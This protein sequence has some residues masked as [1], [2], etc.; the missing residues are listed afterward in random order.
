MRDYG[1][2]SPSFWTGSTG[3]LL[4]KCPESQ[5]VAIYLMTCPQANMIGLYYMP[6]MYVGHETGL[7]IE[8]ASKGLAWA[9]E[10]GFCSY[11]SSTEMVW[12]HEMAFYQIADSLKSGDKRIKG[13][14]N[15]YDALPSNPYMQAF[16]AKYSK[17]FLMEKCRAEIVECSVNIEA[18]SMPLASHEHEQEHEQENKKHVHAS[19]DAP[20]LKP[21][22][23]KDESQ[24]VFEHWTKVMGKNASTKFTP[25]RKRL[26]VRNLKEGYTVDQLK[27]A[28]DGCYLS[29][30]NMGREQGKPRQYNDIELILRDAKH[31][32]DFTAL[33]NASSPSTNGNVARTVSEQDQKILDMINAPIQT[34]RGRK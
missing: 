10:S 8:G 24:S 14:Q 28:I 12:V 11:D 6:L 5:I 23:F 33:K 30:F 16:Y 25:D 34:G 21:E 4:R 17:A 20:I 27:T 29:D 26:I 1:K 9:C 2:V 18:P 7:G 3:K 22:K 13:I 15:Q 19:E 32:E 31:I